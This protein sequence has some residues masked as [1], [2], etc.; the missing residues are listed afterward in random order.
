MRFLIAFEGLAIASHF[1]ALV[2]LLAGPLVR[3][4]RSWWQ[5]LEPF[6]F[7]I[8][9]SVLGPKGQENQPAGLILVP[10]FGTILVPVFGAV[11]FARGT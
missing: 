4:A 1:P 11:F 10:V 7:Q 2:I 5:F 8:L 6:W 9:E 3:E